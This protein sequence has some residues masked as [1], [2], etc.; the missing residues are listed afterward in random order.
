MGIV[1]STR[2]QVTLLK[3]DLAFGIVCWT[4]RY[5]ENAHASEVVGT[6]TVDLEKFDSEWKIVV[7]HTSFTEM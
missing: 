3:P 1:N 4:M 7:L 2:V 5:P 6:T